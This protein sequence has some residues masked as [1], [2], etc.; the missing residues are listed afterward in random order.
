MVVLTTIF[1]TLLS[2][3]QVVILV[4]TSTISIKILVYLVSLHI[5]SNTDLDQRLGAPQLSL[6]AL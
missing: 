3:L 2:E 6:T 1:M 5:M 4:V